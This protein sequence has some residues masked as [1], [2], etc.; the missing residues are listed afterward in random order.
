M[1]RPDTNDVYE[2]AVLAGHGVAA[3]TT[4][5]REA[6]LAIAARAFRLSGPA[7]KPVHLVHHAISV[8]VY[9]T[10]GGGLR[11][12]AAGAGRVAATRAA[13]DPSRRPLAETPR[14]NVVVGALNGA[15]G[16]R[17]A[18]RNSPL[19]L[20]MTVRRDGR[21][22]PLDADSLAADYPD[23]TGDV[24]VWLH[25]LCE[26]DRSWRLAAREHWGDPTST[27]GSR[28]AAVTPTTSVHLRYNS[29][30]HICDNGDA[31]GQLLTAIVEQWP[32]TVER[33]TLVGH[34]MGG[35]VIRA[36]C[37]TGVERAQPWVPL[38][39]R[40]VYLGSPHLGAPLELAAAATTIA[41]RRLPE[42]RAVGDALASRSV[43]IKDLRYADVRARDWADF[44]DLDAWR[45]EPAECAELLD[46][47]E[48]YY[49]GAT[50]GRRHDTVAARVIGDALVPFVS[51]S[52]NGKRRRLA[53]DVVR[54]RHLGGL[55]HLD[56]LNHPRVYAVLEDWLAT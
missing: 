50:I 2:A 10:V 23:A 40:V 26:T 1:D 36:A 8:G 25:G 51:A 42:T 37:H 29:G 28:L 18:Q 9:R 44:D 49:I 4:M 34:S 53:L 20:Q 12:A 27:H 21:D 48:H 11:L 13:L 39:R 14:G 38:V 54:G 24:V 55:H 5:I 47:A 17:L 46:T 56:L 41:L 31:L 52:G 3:A 30:L 19:A 35:L 32:T 7:A 16:D 15:W 22:V 33:L 45:D 6:H 43:G